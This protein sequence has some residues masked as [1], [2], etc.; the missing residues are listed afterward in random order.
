MG[1]MIHKVALPTKAGEH[2]LM[3]VG[4]TSQYLSFV[5]YEGKPYMVL[6]RHKSWDDPSFKDTPQGSRNIEVV[7]FSWGEFEVEPDMA[8]NYM[9]HLDVPGEGVLF[10]FELIAHTRLALPGGGISGTQLAHP[11]MQGI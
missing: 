9:G 7:A 8:A 10:Y 5:L 2:K 4:P 3:N 1:D 6:I 11:P